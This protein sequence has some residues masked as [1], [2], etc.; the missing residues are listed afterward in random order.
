MSDACPCGS[1]H[2]YAACCGPYHAG[3]EAPTAEALMRSRYSAFARR[4][5]AYLIR[6]LAPLA[7]GKVRAADFRASFALAWTRLEVLAVRDGGPDDATGIVHFRAHYLVGGRPGVL[8]EVS[9]F[10]RSGGAW[11]YRDGRGDPG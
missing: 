10:A 4:D 8:D 9:R 7:R 3:G 11:V 1:G 5:A 2:A 6:T